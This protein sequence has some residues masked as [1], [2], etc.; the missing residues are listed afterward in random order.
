MTWVLQLYDVATSTT[1]VAEDLAMSNPSAAAI[2]QQVPGTSVCPAGCMVQALWDLLK[3]NFDTIRGIITWLELNT[4]QQ[5][6]YI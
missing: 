1:L 2:K 4:E 6:S 3:E 5:K